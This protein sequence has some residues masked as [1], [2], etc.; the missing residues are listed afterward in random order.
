MVA[1]GEPAAASEEVSEEAARTAAGRRRQSD[2]RRARGEGR[3]DDARECPPGA[4][5]HAEAWRRDTRVDAPRRAAT[6]AREAFGLEGQAS[7][8]PS[9]QDTNFR[10]DTLDASY[11]LRLAHS[12]EDPAALAFQHAILEHLE[13]ICDVAGD[14]AA[15]IGSDY[16][17]AISPPHDVPGADTYPVLVQHMLNR[18]WSEERI[19]KVLGENFLRSLK[20]LRPG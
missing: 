11:I 1:S 10:I 12:G 15:A 6:L 20:D 4:G 7:A 8:L 19:R 16:D 2:G 17:G 3:V 9:Y 13:H 14:D 5:N 18:G